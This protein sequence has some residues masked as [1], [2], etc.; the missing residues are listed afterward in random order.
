[1]EKKDL[2][3]IL[4]LVMIGIAFLLLGVYVL[5]SLILFYPIVMFY[6]FH[7]TGIWQTKKRAKVGTIAIVI[8]SLASI[9][10][11]PLINNSFNSYYDQYHVNSAG[12]GIVKNVV[13]D[14]FPSNYYNV[15]LYTTK[16]EMSKIIIL[17]ENS[18]SGNYLPF[19][20]SVSNS[21]YVNGSY[22]THFSMYVGN[23]TKGIYETNITMENGTVYVIILAPRIMSQ[24]EYYSTINNIA[25][26]YTLANITTLTFL[27]SEG[28]FL[29][30]IFGAHIMRKG[31][32]TIS[33]Q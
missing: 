26:V 18:T 24:N 25:L 17:K 20:T 12:E 27:A 21:T 15:T 10:F 7:K 32:Q 5:G 2:K 29:A 9:A 19:I 16:N 22:V 11:Y 13:F 8:V 30:I 33:K 3:F 31:R 28:F 4:Y 1:M 14:P 23:F 6:L